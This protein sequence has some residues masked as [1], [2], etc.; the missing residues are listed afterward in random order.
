MEFKKDVKDGN[1][2][3]NDI[4]KQQAKQALLGQFHAGI[5]G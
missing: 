3:C 2:A 5:W 1:K 4:R